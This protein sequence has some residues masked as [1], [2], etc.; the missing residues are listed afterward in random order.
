MSADCLQNTDVVILAGGLGSRLRS[1]FP[2]LPKCLAPINGV[3]FLR[4]YLNW[5]RRF[6]VQ[7]VILSLGYKSEM[8][9][10]YLKVEPPIDMEIETFVESIPL[11]TGGALR[12]ALSLVRS[13]TVLVTNGDSLACA[14]LSAFKAFHKTK[15]AEVSILLTR[16]VE[17][18]ASGLV[19]TDENDAVTAFS[20]KPAGATNEPAY[21]NA[22]M[23]LMQREAILEIPPDKPVS[24][25]RDIF[26]GLCGRH[27][28]ALKGAFPFID[29]GTP[30]TYSRAAAFFEEQAA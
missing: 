28:Y 15:K 27:F 19:E 25:E 21:I 30:E 4:R 20:E 7:R 26:P 22:G 9:Q 11:G 24:L 23:Y 5:L 2:D 29:I 16:S 13:S 8:I 17:T 12:A 1:L 6:G 3:P 10:D 14:D 18:K